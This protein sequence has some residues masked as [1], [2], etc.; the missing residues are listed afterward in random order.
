MQKQNKSGISDRKWLNREH[1]DL[2]AAAPRLNRSTPNFC[3]L[4]QV[5]AVGVGCYGGLEVRLYN[6]QFFVSHKCFKTLPKNTPLRFT[7][8]TC[9]LSC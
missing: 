4:L 9:S 1:R 2:W 7:F 6:L 8:S 3:F 5:V